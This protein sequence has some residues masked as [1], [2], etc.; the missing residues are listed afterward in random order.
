MDFNSIIVLFRHHI[1][2]VERRKRAKVTPLLMSR[3]KMKMKLNGQVSRRPLPLAEKGDP[4]QG[5]AKGKLGKLIAIQLY[6]Q[7]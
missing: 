1:P 3:M 6:N 2:L 7:K 5:L 4:F